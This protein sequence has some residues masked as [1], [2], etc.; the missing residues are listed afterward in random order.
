MGLFNWSKKKVSIPEIKEII[1]APVKG[2]QWIFVPADSGPWPVE[3]GVTVDILDVKD[4]W[5]RYDMG[6]IFRDERRTVE[7]FT[8]MYRK[9]Q[10][11]E[12]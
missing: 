10:R 2:E 7:T 6:R 3:N 11:T 12:S 8:R 9:V 4:G 5:V 1:T